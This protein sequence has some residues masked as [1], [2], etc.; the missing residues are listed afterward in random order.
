MISQ[1]GIAAIK[2]RVKP[3]RAS[4]N[5]G[6]T[7]QIP[8]HVFTAIQDACEASEITFTAYMT[9]AIKQQAARDGLIGGGKNV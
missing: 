1:Q 6:T 5:R 4:K 3:K 7:L 9:D 2:A 8:F